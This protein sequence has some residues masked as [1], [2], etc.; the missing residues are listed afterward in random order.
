MLK[1]ALK[2]IDKSLVVF[3]E[4]LMA[5][6][7]LDVTWQVLSRFVVRHPSPYTEELARFLL[8]WIGLL[9]SSY[10]YRHKMHLGVDVLVQKFSVENRVWV[11]I[12]IHT[13]VLIFTLAVM[14]WGGLRLVFLVFKLNQISAALQVRMGYVYIVVPL[15]GILISFYALL[16]LRDAFLQLKGRATERLMTTEEH[17]LSVD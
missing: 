14:V 5:F 2:W 13:A 8:I 15:S 4:F 1:T 11:E 3:L 12:F 7:V 16:F 10:A 9:G 17:V 6:I